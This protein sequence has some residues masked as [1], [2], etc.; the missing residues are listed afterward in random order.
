MITISPDTPGW[1]TPEMLEVRLSMLTSQFESE[2]WK[3]REDTLT[4]LVRDLHIVEWVTEEFQQ[5]LSD[6]VPDLR[7][8]ILMDKLVFMEK[9]P[10]SFLYNFWYLLEEIPHLSALSELGKKELDKRV[11]GA[12]MKS[13]TSKNDLLGDSC[14]D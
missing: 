12:E 3:V 6:I 2:W 7:R 11:R 14:Q 4:T 9:N 1:T 8:S 5:R 10:S 13:K